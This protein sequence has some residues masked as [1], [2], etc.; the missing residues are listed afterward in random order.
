MKATPIIITPFVG[1]TKPLKPSNSVVGDC[2]TKKRPE[3]RKYKKIVYAWLF[4]LSA[5]AV[6]EK[7]L[8]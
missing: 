5:L 1:S 4:L 7:L 3:I 8:N 6:N 2:T